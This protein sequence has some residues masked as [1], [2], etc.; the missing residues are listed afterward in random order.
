[1]KINGE[2]YRN[3]LLLEDL[4]PDVQELSEFFI[5]QQDSAPAHRTRE[6]AELLQSHSRLHFPDSVAPE[7]P[8]PESCGLQ[9][10]GHHARERLQDE[11]PGCRQYAREL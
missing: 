8:G 2:Y 1:M 6:T 11:G 7:Q 9:D 4:L 10:L 3:T 5:F